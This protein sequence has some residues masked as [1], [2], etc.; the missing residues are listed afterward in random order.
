VK[1]FSSYAFHVSD[2]VNVERLRQL[3]QC[4][5]AIDGRKRHLRLEGLWV[6]PAHS[7]LH[8]RS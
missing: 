1:Y 7:S 3:R 8:A 6:I 2:W 5:I 4:L